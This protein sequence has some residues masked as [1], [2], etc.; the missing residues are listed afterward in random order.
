MITPIYD[1]NQELLWLEMA[2]IWLFSCVTAI[3]VLQNLKIVSM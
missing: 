2:Q 3:I 1:K